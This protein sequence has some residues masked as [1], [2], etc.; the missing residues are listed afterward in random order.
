M[1]IK[2]KFREK[3]TIGSVEFNDKMAIELINLKP[4]DY[5]IVPSYTVKH[6]EGKEDG[7]ILNNY[8]LIPRIYYAPNEDK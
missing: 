7:F 2:L 4:G 5:V 8:S 1:R 6:Q 3:Q